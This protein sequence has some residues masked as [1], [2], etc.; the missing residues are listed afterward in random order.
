MQ[1]N[2]LRE[3]MIGL[4]HDKVVFSRVGLYV[5]RDATRMIIVDCK[6]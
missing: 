5:S 3:D 1:K 4:T 6:V 2:Y